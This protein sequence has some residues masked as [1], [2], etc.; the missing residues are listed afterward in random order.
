MP[1]HPIANSVIGD[2][3]IG[4]SSI[5]DSSI[6]DSSIGVVFNL[7]THTMMIFDFSIYKYEL[8]R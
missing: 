1:I 7:Q 2:S 5:G 4:D 8:L 6:G 3:S